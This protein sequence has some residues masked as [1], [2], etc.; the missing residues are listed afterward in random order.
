MY[1]CY[2]WLSLLIAVQSQYFCCCSQC[3]LSLMS[4]VVRKPAFCICENKDA[5][6]LAVTAKLISAFVFATWIVQFLFYLNP[7]FQASSHLLWLY[8]PVCVRPGRKPEGRFSHNEAHLCQYRYCL[9]QIT[10][11]SVKRVWVAGER[12]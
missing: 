2:D 9:V 11:S 12:A 4:R 1:I 6:Q 5:D 10:F 7:K 8:S 3:C